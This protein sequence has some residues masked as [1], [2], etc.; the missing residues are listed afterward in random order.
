MTLKESEIFIETM[1]EFGDVWTSEQVMTV[2]GQKSLQ[3]AIKERRSSLSKLM[4]IIA[5]F[6][7]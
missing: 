1:K 5:K 6:I 4:D 2:Y 7:N 3:E